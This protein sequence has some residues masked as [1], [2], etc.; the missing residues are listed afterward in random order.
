MRIHSYS[1]GRLLRRFALSGLA[2]VLVASCATGSSK[3]LSPPVLADSARTSADPQLVSEWLLAELLSPGGDAKRGGEARKRLDELA[4][5][6]MLAHLGRGL[7]DA[8]HG[9]LTTAPEHFMRAVRAAR[10]SSDPR[11]PYLAWYALQRAHSLRHGDPKLWTRWKDFVEESMHNP[12]RLDWRARGDLVDWWLAEAEAAAQTN[13]SEAAVRELGCVKQVRIAGPFGADHQAELM[14]TH[15]AELPGPWPQTWPAEPDQRGTPKQQTTEHDH[16]EVSAEDPGS[17]GVYYAETYIELPAE[18]ELLLAVRGSF[19]L[20][21]DD[22]LVSNRDPRLWGEWP[23]FGVGLKLAAGRHR[24]LARLAAP[25]TTLRL[26]HPNGTPA[27]VQT[28]LDAKRPYHLLPPLARWEPNLVSRWVVDGNA[29]DPQ[30][31]LLRVLV[32]Q[33]A[34]TDGQGDLASILIEPLLAKVEDAP[35]A[36][37]AMAAAFT[38]QDPIYDSSQARDLVQELHQRAAAKDP[39]LLDAQLALAA[40]DAE[41][42]GA[43]RTVRR[44]EELAT[45]FPDAPGPLWELARLQ[46]EQGWEPERQHT[47]RLLLE[48]FPESL[49]AIAAAIEMLDRAGERDKAEAL[50]SQMMRLSPDGELRLDRLL[51]RED[52]PGAIAELERLKARRPERKHYAERIAELQQRRAASQETQA[53]LIKA[54]AD[55]P[56]KGEPRLALADARFASNQAR[57]LEDALA[58]A[59]SAGAQTEELALAKDLISGTT[60]L[61]PFR[62]DGRQVIAQFEASGKHLP[63]TAARILDRAAVWVRSDGSSRML[64]HEIVRIQS[65]EAI[66]RFAEQE[67]SKGL[68]LNLRVIKKD[69]EV[70]EPIFVAGKPSVTMPHLEVGDYIETE[71]VVGFASSDG[72]GARYVGPTWFFREADIAYSRSEF[73]AVLPKAVTPLIETRGQV[74]APRV[75]VREGVQI[76]SW[77]VDDS[78]A[79]PIEPFSAPAVEF[80]PTVRVGW[81]S[82][83]DLRLRTLSRSVNQ[84]APLDPRVV[85]VA[86]RIVGELPTTALRQRAEALYRWVLENVEPGEEGDARR[87]I[88]GKSGS[89]WQAYAMLCSAVGLKSEF[90]VVRSNLA[91]AAPGPIAEAALYDSPLLRVET[92]GGWQ[93][94][95]FAAQGRDQVDRYLPFGYLPPQLRGAEGFTIGADKPQ[96]VVVNTSPILDRQ[97]HEGTVTLAADGSAVMD[98]VFIYEGRTAMELRA[99]IAQLPEARLH[100]ILESQLLGNLLDGATLIKHE[101]L[102]LADVQAPLRLK[103]QAKV[104]SFAQNVGGQL[105]LAPPFMPKVSQLTTL[106]TRATPLLLALPTSQWLTLRITL[107]AGTHVVSTLE[108][109]NL[110]EDGRRVQVRDRLEPSGI[111]VMERL[112]ELPTGRVP[113]DRYATLVDFARRA[114]EALTTPIRIEATH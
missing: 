74:P 47:V 5:D 87:I 18:Q 27:L 50:V 62:I 61:E 81:G 13:T 67:R 79:A 46:G 58:A 54:V 101:L 84:L 49:E 24:L 98:L 88:I 96:S 19:A 94:L 55:A 68:V 56:T 100:D 69:G 8:L 37:L 34:A 29:L 80:L 97:G 63:G 42:L 64:E 75:E 25:S 92:E 36:I 85:R 114:D 33:L 2:L 93:W 111:L 83:L 77:R 86:R 41:R 60:E 32:A 110:D 73:I 30:D 99:A 14:R 106:P 22:H 38:E 21:V 16:C 52:W 113:T 71:Q 10:Q 112:L 1:A 43:A 51:A 59:V 6:G 82:D 57:A 15:A 108:P 45:Q 78:P 26:L 44:L 3:P 20:W 28:D 9:R 40:S 103:V 65:E 76:F 91:A 7:D 89:R 105:L 4:A 53:E 23:R 104:P 12:G 102:E 72:R 107:P 95:T 31:D 17:G 11:A 90:A 39:A 48:R 109:V 35:A 66:S 70:L